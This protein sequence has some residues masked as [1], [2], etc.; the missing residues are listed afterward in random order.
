MSETAS[1]RPL[2][3]SILTLLLAMI[4]IQS[5]AA[6]AKGLFAAV[7][8]P[9]TATLRAGLAAMMLC[10]LWRP[11]QTPLT[12]A[13][14]KPV[15]AYG[16]AL[17]C[18]NLSFYLA[19]A[20]IPL[21][22]AVA[23][24]FMGPLALALLGSR[25]AVDFVWG[26]LAIGGVALL[27]PIGQFSARLDPLGVLL[28]LVAGLCWAVY[29]ICGQKAVAAAGGRSSATLG[30]L[31][32]ACLV[33]PIGVADA[34]TRL[35]QPAILPAALAVALFSSALPYS[36]EMIALRHLPARTFGILMSLEPALAAMSGLAILH[37]Q[38]SPLQWL[39][40]GLIMAASL[41]SSL[42]ARAAMIG[43]ESAA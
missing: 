27:M 31:V 24:E 15:L 12:R 17:G 11:W 26:L 20:R 1:L 23:L 30:M 25:K 28:A 22:I 39:A 9:G 21:G 29:I 37:E 10:L 19:L 40:I 5:G 42:S 38:L 34:G 13:Q 16:L 3:V 35:L 32:A 6:V 41:G 14:A 43:P 2:V 4:S 8:A 7:G 18:M 33:L 36:L